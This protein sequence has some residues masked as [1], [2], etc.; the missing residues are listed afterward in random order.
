LRFFDREHAI[1]P[2]AEFLGETTLAQS[3]WRFVRAEGLNVQV[4][5]LSPI[6]TEHADR[7]ALAEHLRET[8]AA[9]LPQD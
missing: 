6:A 4:H 3:L 9:A 7:R 8:I 1:S 5:V 2:L